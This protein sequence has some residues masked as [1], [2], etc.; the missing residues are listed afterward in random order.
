[1]GRKVIASTKMAT[2]TK[3]LF[4]C[5]CF[6]YRIKQI[7]QLNPISLKN[8]IRYSSYAAA[9]KEN[10]PDAYTSFQEVSP[11]NWKF[12]ERLFPPTFVPPFPLKESYTSGW[13]PPSDKGLTFPFFIPRNKNHMIPVYLNF[14]AVRGERKITIVRHIEGD[15]W[16]LE[17]RLKQHL[18]KLNGKPT[19]SQVHEVAMFIKFKGDHVSVVKEWLTDCGF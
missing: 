19:V 12:V 13:A 14:E 9:P 6:N 17:R 8:S 4:M 5:R 18:G 16:E 1:M 10:S 11:D 15:I 2:L 7:P 3:H